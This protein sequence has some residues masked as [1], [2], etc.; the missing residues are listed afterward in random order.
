MAAAASQTACAICQE[1][2]L[3][4]RAREE[5]LGGLD[6]CGHKFCFECVRA[7]SAEATCC[8]MCKAVATALLRY[9]AGSSEPVERIELQAADNRQ[10]G[11]AA[12][13]D[14]QAEYDGLLECVACRGEADQDDA[15]RASID[16]V[17][18]VRLSR[19]AHRRAGGQSLASVPVTPA[20]NSAVSSSE[21]TT[22][23]R[24]TS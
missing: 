9:R 7:W 10:A 17:K 8:P 6:G 18:L 1:D 14:T 4:E 22:P 23:P 20:S 11:F 2:A 12:V 3:E 13:A 15:A 24:C 5:Q 19:T 16:A 21:S